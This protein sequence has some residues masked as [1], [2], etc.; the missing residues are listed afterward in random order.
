MT[1]ARIRK[2]RTNKL[3][4]KTAHAFSICSLTDQTP[5]SLC[6]GTHSPHKSNGLLFR[7][8]NHAIHICTQNLKG[9]LLIITTPQFNEKNKTTRSPREKLGSPPTHKTHKNNVILP[10]L[11][12]LL[13]LHH[14]GY[15]E[16]TIPPHISET[17]PPSDYR[18]NS[19][20]EQQCSRCSRQLPQLYTTYR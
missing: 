10:A 6:G 14:P 3:K 12:Y 4:V 16:I 13:P 2:R 18:Q 19:T 11:S 17:T 5:S 7:T 9:L 1:F 15:Y 20:F 8:Q